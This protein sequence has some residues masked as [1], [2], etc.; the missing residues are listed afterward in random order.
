M[1][2]HPS[3]SEISVPHIQNRNH[4]RS[5]DRCILGIILV[6]DVGW[7]LVGNLLI[8]FVGSCEFCVFIPVSVK[9]DPET[10]PFS[11]LVTSLSP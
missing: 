8:V 11:V 6:N 4:V 10:I 1:D 5:W 3:P 7:V 9:T 2:A